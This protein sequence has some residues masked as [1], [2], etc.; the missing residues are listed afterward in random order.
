[1]PSIAR[2]IAIGYPHHVVQR[3]NN[4]KEVSLAEKDRRQYLDYFVKYASK[5][6]TSIIACCLM[7]NCVHL[8]LRPKR[9]RLY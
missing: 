5:L 7:T 9:E 3:G 4:R 6:H 2:A 8:L 1:M